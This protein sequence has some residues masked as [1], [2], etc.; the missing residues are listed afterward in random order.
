M[1]HD[2]ILSVLQAQRNVDNGPKRIVFDMHL[3]PDSSAI[4]DVFYAVNDNVLRV[5]WKRDGSVGTWENVPVSVA[6]NI[7]YTDE[8]V[9]RQVNTVKANY[10]ALPE[11]RYEFATTALVKITYQEGK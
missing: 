11:D 9:G 3:R 1:A 5:H 7:F 10:Q 4:A 8:S 2:P 6:Y